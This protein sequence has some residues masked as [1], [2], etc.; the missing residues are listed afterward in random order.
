MTD[1]MFFSHD[2]R[3]LTRGR[4]SAARTETCRPCLVLAH[5]RAFEG[6]ILNLT[7]HGM[8]IRCLE[9]LDLGASVDV[10]LMRDDAFREP[11]SAPRPAEVVRRAGSGEGFHDI[12][13]RLIH[14]RIERPKPVPARPV[15][16]PRTPEQ[17][18]STRMHTL[19]VTVGDHGFTKT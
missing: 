17:R 6:V 11:M 3:G 7:P 4:R 14:E 9:P 5:D 16:L 15:S 19:D 1:T 18:P 13:L 2:E 10:Q 8:L 12:A